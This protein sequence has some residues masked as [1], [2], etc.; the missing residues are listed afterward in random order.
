MDCLRASGSS[1]PSDSISLSRYAVAPS[2]LHG[3]SILVEIEGV[4]GRGFLHACFEALELIVV[5]ARVATVSRMISD[6]F[7]LRAHEG[8]LERASERLGQ[9]WEPLVDCYW[10]A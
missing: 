6:R 2:E 10:A 1:G 7:W 5:E 8:D 9:V 3:G 4:D